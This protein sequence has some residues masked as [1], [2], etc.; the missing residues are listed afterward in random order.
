MIQ[1]KKPVVLCVIDGFGLSSTWR[2]NAIF[3]ASPKNFFEIWGNY[4]HHLLAYS[5]KNPS[6][7]V[8]D[9]PERYLA[10][11]LRGREVESEREY[12]DNQIKKELLSS[13]DVLKG[14]FKQAL[15]RNSSLHLIGNLSEDSGKYSNFEHL[16]SLL[17][18]AKEKNLFRVFVHLI[19]D[20]TLDY[21]QILKGIQRLEMKIN[22]TGL[23]E[24]ASICGLNFIQE[25][26][27]SFLDFSKAYKAIVEGRGN[28]Y[29]SAEQAI[30]KNKDTFDSPSNFP[31]SVVTS[32]D[33]PIG[34]ISDFDSIIFFNHNNSDL[35]KL[36]LA[37]SSSSDSSR[38]PSPK[39]LY[40]ATFFDYI[41][42]KPD[43]L[44]VLFKRAGTI[45]LPH[46]LCG[47]GL[48]QL[49]IS[50]ST[51]MLSIK[52]QLNGFKEISGQPSEDFVPVLDYKQYLNNPKPII[53]EIFSKTVSAVKEKKYD[54]IFIDVPCIDEIASN[55]TFGQALNAT[56]M[57]DNFLPVLLEAVLNEGGVLIITSTY[58]NA[59]KMVRRDQYEILNGRTL[60]PVPFILASSESKKEMKSSSI[61]SELMYD[62]ITKKNYLRDIAPTIIELFNLPIPTEFTG[63]NLMS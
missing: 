32:K 56:K 11:L 22:Q 35:T 63:H 17:E 46:I 44:N 45:D 61:V 4:I 48:N 18:L 59:E 58:G 8:Y 41:L 49:Y 55:G 29:L 40:L 5:S 23:G 38:L 6:S 31:P 54:F 9:N 39:F 19:I 25:D 21:K 20:S 1:N 3:S 34:V 13:N 16:L 26:K 15:D 14:A 50:D 42:P 7:A 10:S 2:G 37:F 47:A 36:I 28:S 43:G 53:Y 52:S 12:I 57:V 60:D 24:I 27:K 62:M 30:N 33:D 51:R